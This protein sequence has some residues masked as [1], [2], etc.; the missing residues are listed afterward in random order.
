M[1][2]A[3]GGQ[4]PHHIGVRRQNSELLEVDL[5]YLGWRGDGVHPYPAT[6][7]YPLAEELLL[8]YSSSGDRVLDPFVGSGTTIRAAAANGR[9]SIGIDLNPLATLMAR[10]SVQPLDVQEDISTYHSSATDVLRRLGKDILTPGERWM[11]RL[12]TWFAPEAQE[13]LGRL[14]AALRR[15]VEDSLEPHLT[16]YLMLA[17]SRTVRLCSLAR[18]GELKLWRRAG[19]NRIANPAMVFDQEASDL[20]QTLVAFQAQHPIRSEWQPVVITGDSEH[21]LHGVPKAELVLTS[22]PYGDSWTTVAYGNFSL[23][24]R[25]WLSAL[26]SGFAENDPATEDARSTGGSSRFRDDRALPMNELLE[27]SDHL[28]QVFDEIRKTSTSRAHELVVFADDMRLILIQV[29]SKL[30]VGGHLV[31][32]VGPRR[33]SGIPVDTG[34]VF[35]DVLKHLGLSHIDRHARRV[36]GKRLPSKTSQGGAGVAETIN[37]ET[38]D[39]FQRV[40]R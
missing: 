5:D 10:V 39:V 22:P 36:S 1:P 27:L 8:R 38:I 29:M 34:L 4:S 30:K 31:M 28:R 20:L 3:A 13:G 37:R 26:D 33:V 2:Y 25:I 21:A 11:P 40:R 9:L 24:S 19:T 17:F 32:V 15:T 16:D 23:L 6:M 35:G 14:A 7:P 18:P 12:Q